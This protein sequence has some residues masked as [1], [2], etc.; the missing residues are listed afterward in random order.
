[1]GGR[2]AK[3]GGKEGK[4]GKEWVV[5][6]QTGA[7]KEEIWASVNLNREI[8]RRKHKKDRFKRSGV[9]SADRK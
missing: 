3:L 5:V 6:I 2:G 9:K 4:L 8:R 7:L 1:M